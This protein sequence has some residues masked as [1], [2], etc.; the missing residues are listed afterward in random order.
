M[1]PSQENRVQMD[2]S[3]YKT[4][5]IKSKLEA[6]ETFGISEATLRRRLGRMKPRAGTRANSHKLTAF[7]EDVLV[8][9]LRDADKRG[10]SIRPEFLREM[11][12]ILLIG[13]SPVNCLLEY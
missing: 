2:I 9:R 12:G 11:A 7:E 3:A 10:F 8:K 4:Q 5:K 13:G 6:A 1:A